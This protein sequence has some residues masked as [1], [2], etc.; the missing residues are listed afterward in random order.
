VPLSLS[1]H[2]LW[3]SLCVFYAIRMLMFAIELPTTFGNEVDDSGVS[4]PALEANRSLPLTFE[5]SHEQIMV[6]EL[7]NNQDNNSLN[8]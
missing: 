6:K 4:L 1:N 5:E 2:I 8:N 3:L 7:Q